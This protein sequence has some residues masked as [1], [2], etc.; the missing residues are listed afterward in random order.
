MTNKEEDITV[1]VP[2][3]PCQT[4]TPALMK[5]LIEAENFDLGEDEDVEA[6]DEEVDMPVRRAG[7]GSYLFRSRRSGLGK[8]FNLL[9]CL[10]LHVVACM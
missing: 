6:D 10:L 3:L 8:L 5:A 2:G 7:S 4:L 1:C 9:L